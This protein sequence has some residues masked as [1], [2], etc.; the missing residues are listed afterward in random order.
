MVVLGH[1]ITKARSSVRRIAIYLPHVVSEYTLCLVRAAGWELQPIDD[2]LSN[3]F[4]HGEGSFRREKYL[5]LWSWTLDTS[6][7]K[8]TSI[9]YLAPNTI[10][11]QNFDE[12]FDLPFV[13]GAAIDAHTDY[14]GFT[15]EFNSGV[16]AVRPDSAV[17][18]DMLSKVRE[19]PK[20]DEQGFLNLYYG[21]QVLRLPHVY[22][23]NLA[24]K[25]I[26]G[27]YWDAIWEEMR[28]VQ[29]TVASPFDREPVCRWL[30]RRVPCAPGQIWDVK[31]HERYISSAKEEMGGYYSPEIEL[32]RG[33]YNEAMLSNVFKQCKLP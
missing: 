10:V 14:R 6:P 32:W 12:L 18:L 29:Y 22:N 30:F 2:T 21:Q 27:A 33:I 4:D 7:T 1:S 24:I 17:F 20:N 15:V 8:L 31:R 11:R 28:I 13:F 26:S 16:M 3:I 9:V 23:G 19:A 5:K 25:L